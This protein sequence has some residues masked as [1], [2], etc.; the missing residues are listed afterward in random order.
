MSLLV[1]PRAV[2][3]DMGGTLLQQVQ[4]EPAAGTR[5][6][7]D[8]AVSGHAATP[9]K[10]DELVQLL[11]ADLGARREASMMEVSP[12]AVQRLVYERLQV[13]FNVSPDEVEA[14]FLRAAWAWKPT[15]G[16]HDALS[17]LRKLGIPMAV[18]SNSA[19]S[20]QA[21]SRELDEHGLGQ[22]FEFTMSSAD[23]VLRKPHPALFH[24]AAGKLNVSREHAWY[25]GDSCQYDVVGAR[26]A[27][28]TAILYDPAGTADQGTKPDA[29]VT[30]WADLT[31]L[32]VS[33][34]GRGRN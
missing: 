14:A 12:W 28:M 15:H 20:T 13:R 24:T 18:I 17:E 34:F 1:E 23:Y 10:V 21:L 27:G 25:V 9:D 31:A 4:W 11:D 33:S 6:V 32:V 22:F 26:A 5:A 3:F 30:T 7:L 29:V 19:F 2:F 16:I 8:L